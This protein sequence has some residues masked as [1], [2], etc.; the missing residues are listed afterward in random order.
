MTTVELN[1]GAEIIYLD[2]TINEQPVDWL[3]QGN[4]VWRAEVPAA[5]DTEYRIAVT[6]YDGAG[7]S[8]TYSETLHYG[9]A[10]VFSRTQAQVNRA[11]YLA[12]KGF[13]AMSTSERAEWLAD[14]PGAY[15]ASDFNRVE[16]SVQFLRDLLREYGYSIAAVNIKTDWQMSD[17]PRTSDASRYLAN[18]EAFR[19]Y[20][21]WLSAEPLPA[22]LENLTW[23][24]ANDI[25]RFLS[26][27]YYYITL[28]PSAYVMSGEDYSGGGLQ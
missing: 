4:G 8:E 6:A 23:Q 5:E 9:L 12:G 21:P 16:S 18:I 13:A 7:N 28:M 19:Y 25:E 17:I 24:G 11:K 27:I 22:D 20:A 14:L 1:F 26:K 15:N 3:S 2:G 10:L